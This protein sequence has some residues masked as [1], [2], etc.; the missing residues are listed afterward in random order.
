MNKKKDRRI[1]RHYKIRQKIAGNS[2]KPRLSIYKSNKF[3]YV[4]LIDD[5]KR[6]VITA[7]SE[8]ELMKRGTKVENAK[9]EGRLIAKKAI[10]KKIKTVVFDRAG[11]AYHGR[12]KSLAEGAREGGLVF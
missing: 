6:V 10:E 5:S 11:F 1:K 7:V 4:Q 2:Q 12:V 3:I 8:K 9:E